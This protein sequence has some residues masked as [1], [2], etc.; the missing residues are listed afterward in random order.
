M[1]GKIL[2]KNMIKKFAVSHMEK[3]LNNGGNPVVLR[4]Q[5]AQESGK[6]SDQ[7]AVWQ[8]DEKTGAVLSCD[9]IEKY[10]SDTLL[11]GAPIPLL[12]AA[13]KHL[14]DVVKNIPD[15]KRYFLIGI[16]DGVAQVVSVSI[17]EKKIESET[18]GKIG[19]TKVVHTPSAGVPLSD[20]LEGILQHVTPQEISEKLKEC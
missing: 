14:S 4:V 8:F 1:F 2:N 6:D 12:N 19:A 3:V 20:V 16:V 13:K 9:A 11:K 7:V 5:R 15:H 10:I 18:E 17:E